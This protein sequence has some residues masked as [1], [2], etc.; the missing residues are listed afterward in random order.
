MPPKGHKK[1]VD[2]IPAKPAK[3]QAS[4][5]KNISPEIVAE[6]SDDE[7][8]AVEAEDRYLQCFS[9]YLNFCTYPSDSIDGGD[10]AEVLVISD[11]DEESNGDQNPVPNLPRPRRK[12]ATRPP[13]TPSPVKATRSFLFF[14][15]IFFFFLIILLRRGKNL[16]TATANQDDELTFIPR[17]ELISFSLISIC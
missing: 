16:T 10:D 3:R 2:S 9:C 1:V 17:Y 4:A 15:Y 5:R 13:D 11:D 7:L 14:F 12:A 6:S 8:I